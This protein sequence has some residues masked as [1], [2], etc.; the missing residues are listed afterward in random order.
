MTEI[1]LNK[2]VLQIINEIDT[3]VI[4]ESMSAIASEGALQNHMHVTHGHPI[5]NEAINDRIV[6]TMRLVLMEVVTAIVL[7][8]EAAHE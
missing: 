5:D 2:R 4:L 7:G 1:Q 6:E 3:K 8:R